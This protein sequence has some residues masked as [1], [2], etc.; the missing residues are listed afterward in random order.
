MFTL[1]NG[2]DFTWKP[3]GKDRELVDGADI[4]IASMEPRRG[5]DSGPQIQI[6]VQTSDY[7]VEAIVMSGLALSGKEKRGAESAATAAKVIKVVA[8]LAGGGIGGIG[9]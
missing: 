2:G 8:S 6:F 1:P 7:M 3:S 5:D 9:N 4:K